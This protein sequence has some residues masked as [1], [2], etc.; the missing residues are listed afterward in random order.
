[1]S[2]CSAVNEIFSA[3]MEPKKAIPKPVAEG[4]KGYYTQCVAC[5]VQ[6]AEL[7]FDVHDIMRHNEWCEAWKNAR[8]EEEKKEKKIERQAP[9]KT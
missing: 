6:N 9:T 4:E 1:M 5:E 3:I 8:A 2:Q 7:K